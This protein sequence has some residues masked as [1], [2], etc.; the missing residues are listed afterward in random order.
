M[1]LLVSPPSNF[2]AAASL[3]LDK[4]IVAGEGAQ[5]FLTQLAIFAPRRRTRFRSSR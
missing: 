3:T 5:T 1:L 4:P 2:P